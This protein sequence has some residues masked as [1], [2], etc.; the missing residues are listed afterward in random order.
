MPHVDQPE[1]LPPPPTHIAISGI[2]SNLITNKKPNCHFMYA[3]LTLL[4]SYAYCT[5]CRFRS[6][7]I[8]HPTFTLPR[9]TRKL[10]AISHTHNCF[11]LTRTLYFGYISLGHGHRC[12]ISYACCHWYI[13][14][15]CLCIRYRT[16][17]TNYAAPNPNKYNR[18]R[19]EFEMLF[20]LL[21]LFH[22]CGNSMAH[23]KV[24]TFRLG[25]QELG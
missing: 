10:V 16:V 15:L 12:F 13:H 6:L 25:V 3:F 5:Y 22:C 8:I 14:C 1:H 18:V 17:A 20:K 21:A 7:H 11:P 19:P 2:Q 9:G 23:T 24:L 4:P